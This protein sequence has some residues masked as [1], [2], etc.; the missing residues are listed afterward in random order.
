MMFL[1]KKAG[2]KDIVVRRDDNRPFPLS[3][4]LRRAADYFP[5][6]RWVLHPLAQVFDRFAILN[7]FNPWDDMIVFARK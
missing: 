7:P 3:F 6:L 4:A 5:F 2:F 1:L